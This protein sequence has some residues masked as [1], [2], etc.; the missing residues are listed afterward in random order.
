MGLALNWRSLSTGRVPVEGGDLQKVWQRGVNHLATGRLYTGLQRESGY[1]PLGR[2]PS[3]TGF[4][5]E[6]AMER[7]SLG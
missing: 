5:A 4:H 6:S 7:L 2:K 3:D 1:W